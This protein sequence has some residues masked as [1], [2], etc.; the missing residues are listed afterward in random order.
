ME[1]ITKRYSTANLVEK[2]DEEVQRILWLLLDGTMLS[3]DGT[4]CNGEYGFGYSE[5]E[6]EKA[7]DVEIEEPR[8]KV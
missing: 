3:A 8:E 6:L 7:L 4:E 2:V 1:P 5:E